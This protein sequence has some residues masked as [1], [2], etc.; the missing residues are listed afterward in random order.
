MCGLGGV[1]N[2]SASGQEWAVASGFPLMKAVSINLRLNISPRRRMFLFS[3]FHFCM[4]RQAIRVS[5][6][7]A[8]RVDSFVQQPRRVQNDCNFLVFFLIICFCRHVLL[9]WCSRFELR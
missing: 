6:Q 5:V 7:H 4:L 3:F 8:S 2:G 9:C 1:R